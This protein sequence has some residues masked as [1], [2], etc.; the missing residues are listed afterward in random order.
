MFWTMFNI[1]P[2]CITD[3]QDFTLFPTR[4]TEQTDLFFAQK[5]HIHLTSDTR[6]QKGT[7]TCRINIQFTVHVFCFSGYFDFKQLPELLL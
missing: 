1:T 4:M 3:L 2:M 6:A 5:S 7:N